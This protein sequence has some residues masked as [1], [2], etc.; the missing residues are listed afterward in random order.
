MFGMWVLDFSFPYPVHI[1]NQIGE[2]MK[3]PLELIS[4]AQ[5]QSD[6]N[7]PKSK[8]KAIRKKSSQVKNG[9]TLQRIIRPIDSQIKPRSIQLDYHTWRHRTN[10]EEYYKA[11]GKALRDW[12]ENDPY[13]RDFVQFTSSIGVHE[14]MLREWARKFPFFQE[15]Y[16]YAKGHIKWKRDLSA[17]SGELPQAMVSQTRHLY[18]IGFNQE[19]DRKALLAKQES[20]DTNITV[21]LPELEATVTEVINTES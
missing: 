4:T 11:V 8:P 20:T 2:T 10:D 6:L 17:A 18:D 5:P 19:Q 15:D 9:E 16:N 3:K 14:D 12:A 13:A 7:K 21:V 1:E